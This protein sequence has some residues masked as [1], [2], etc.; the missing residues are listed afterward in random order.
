MR[1]KKLVILTTQLTQI[2]FIVLIST[3]PP[4]DISTQTYT[5]DLKIKQYLLHNVNFEYSQKS[6]GELFKLIQMLCGLQ[7]VYSQHKKSLVSQL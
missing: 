4:P 7:H 5:L 2:L 3:I 6:S 1:Y